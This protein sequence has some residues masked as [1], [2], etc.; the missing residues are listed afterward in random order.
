M[1]ERTPSPEDQAVL[2]HDNADE[3]PAPD[4]PPPGM[5]AASGRD[6]VTREQLGR[7]I[8]KHERTIRRW[9]RTRLAP[10]VLVGKD[11]THRFDL[12]RVREL[13]EIREGSARVAPASFDDGE[14]TAAVFELFAQGVE[15]VEVVMR[16]RLPA[17]A[18]Q[19]LHRQW[20]SLRGGY[21]VDRET[22][23]AISALRGQTILDAAKLLRDL[24]ETPRAACDG[25]HEEFGDAR[26]IKGRGA[27]FC[28]LCASK[29]STRRAAELAAAAAADRAERQRRREQQ[30][31][32]AEHEK[33]MRQSEAELYRMLRAMRGQGGG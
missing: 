6:V 14:T 18:V 31:S 25:C 10:A 30:K 24:R 29:L 12:A 1:N 16:T 21:V 27:A 22:A 3:Q 2:S 5:A 26:D 15:P 17:S 11:G 33:A 19:G 7:M 23:R 20:A 32:D 4:T 13:V 8:G 28:G 9:E